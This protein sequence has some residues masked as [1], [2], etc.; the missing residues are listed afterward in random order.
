M[1]IIDLNFYK[2]SS[3]GSPTAQGNI[4]SVLQIW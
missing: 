1:Y 2:P 3:A 4:D